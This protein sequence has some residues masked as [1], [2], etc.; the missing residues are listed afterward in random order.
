MRQFGPATECFLCMKAATLAAHYSAIST[1]AEHTLTYTYRHTCQG[2]TF[3]SLCCVLV[4]S[5]YRCTSLKLFL[6]YSLFAATKLELTFA[7]QARFEER[8]RSNSSWILLQ[9][10]GYCGYNFASFCSLLWLTF[11]LNATLFLITM[12]Y[13]ILILYL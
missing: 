11:C 9:T 13:F 6:V 7:F 3:F 2:V 1:T 12:H 8:R 5:L 10:N 4:H